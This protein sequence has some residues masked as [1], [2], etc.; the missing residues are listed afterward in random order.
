MEAHSLVSPSIAVEVAANEGGKQG[1]RPRQFFSSISKKDE[2]R[3]MRSRNW[4]PVLEEKRDQ[5][6]ARPFRYRSAKGRAMFRLEDW[7]WRWDECG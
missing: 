1:L 3:I 6:R 7:R 4:Y 2:I 5:M